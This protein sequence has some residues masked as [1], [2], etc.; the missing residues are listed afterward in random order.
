MQKDNEN[1][2]SL[3][4]ATEAVKMAL[5]NDL[6]LD[7]NFIEKVAEIVHIKWLERNKSKA[8]EVDKNL[9]STLPESEKEKDRIFVREAIKQRK[10]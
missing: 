2:I 8:T 10:I 7:E 4:I 3:E 1:K 6:A 9:Y 5:E